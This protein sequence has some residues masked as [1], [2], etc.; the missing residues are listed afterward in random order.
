MLGSLVF[1]ALGRSTEEQNRKNDQRQHNLMDA[2][3]RSNH[4][5]VSG[6][7]CK[8]EG[9]PQAFE[10][11]TVPDYTFIQFG[12]LMT[13]HSVLQEPSGIIMSYDSQTNVSCGRPP[14]LHHLVREPPSLCSVSSVEGFAMCEDAALKSEAAVCNITNQRYE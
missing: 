14:D 6:L 11:R 5:Q 10:V 1:D 7:K 9:P 8:L 2:G 3:N 12:P 13:H 4:P